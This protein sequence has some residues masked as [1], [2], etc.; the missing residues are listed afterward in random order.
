MNRLEKLI[1]KMHREQEL[2]KVAQPV[3]VKTPK[4]KVPR[5][6]KV[7]AVKV[8]K[9]APAAH[10][11]TLVFNPPITLI[12]AVK[13]LTPA[14]ASNPK[15]VAGTITLFIIDQIMRTPRKF[16]VMSSA[17]SENLAWLTAVPFADK[18]DLKRVFSTA[19]TLTDAVECRGS[20]EEGEAVQRL[21]EIERMLIER[22]MEGAQ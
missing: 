6:A 8:A 16:D 20:C 22:K 13:Q 3:K 14:E 15:I 19:L 10:E 1:E 2:R 17:M 7:K 18:V 21:H 11:E 4:V 9:P 12:D 5:I